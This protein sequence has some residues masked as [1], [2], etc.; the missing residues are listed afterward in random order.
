MNYKFSDIKNNITFFHVQEKII[1]AIL[2][3]IA[4]DSRNI[5]VP[6][7]ALFFALKGQRLDAHEFIMEAYQKGVRNFIVNKTFD[8]QE[9]SDANF[10]AVDNVVHA[11]QEIATFHRKHF[12]ITTIGIT[13]SNGKTIIKEWLFQ[14]LFQDH[15]I[16]RS[17]RSY[18]SQIGVPLS[19]LAI[20]KQH[21]LAIFEAGI[22]RINEMEKLANVIRCNIG[23]FTNIGDAHD[24]GFMSRVQKIKEKMKLF[25]FCDIL[26]LCN[27]NDQ[28]MK[29]VPKKIKT[30]TWGKTKNA[31]L[32][33]NTQKN[34]MTFTST[35]SVTQKNGQQFNYTIPFIDEA[36]IENSIHCCCLML[37]LGYEIAVI[38]RRMIQL[39]AVALRLELKSGINNCLIIN[40]FYNLDVTSLAFAMDFMTQQ[41]LHTKRTL[42]LSDIQQSG[43]APEQLY[44][45]VAQLI[46][47]HQINKVIAIGSTIVNLLPLISQKTTY[48]HY[49]TTQDFLT[50]IKSQDFYQET[51]LLKGARSFEFERIA[52]L[53]ELKAHQTIMEINLDALRHNLVAYTRKLSPPTKMLVM[54]KAS[55]YGSG[56]A[57]IAKLLEYHKVDYLGVA[58]TDEAVA[59][60][61]EG[62]KLPILVLNPEEASFHALLH[63]DIEPEIYS[64]AQL[65]GLLSYVENTSKI[66]NIHIKLDTGMH[67]L[68]FEMPDIQLL[69]NILASQKKLY[70]KSIFSHLAASDATEHDD[71][72]TQQV[73]QFLAMYEQIATAIGYRPLRHICNTSG[74]ARFPQYHFDMVRLGIGIYG[75][76]SSQEMQSDLQVVNT[77]KATI[78]QIKHIPKGES[79]GYSRRGLAERDLR[80]GTISIGYADGFLRAAGNG[81]YQ[82]AIHGKLAPIIGNVCMDMC[83]IDLTEIQEAKEGDKVTIFGD[84]PRVETLAKATQTIAYEVFTNISERVKR[85]YFKE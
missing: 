49:N 13:G 56:S 53:L 12:A 47:E 82:V 6:S 34:K 54:V 21:D 71:F 85:I 58:Y 19:I 83:M 3:H 38:Q 4:M 68:G 64:L 30:F 55:A 77:L 24:E 48:L 16:V 74:I 40:D 23:I 8:F 10:I 52:E 57:E 43:L 15:F 17:P 67:R 50:N 46:V 62:I 72:T 73:N 2:S 76:D 78:S 69:I 59:L 60:R 31:D 18:N 28:I 27:D 35:I 33:V 22:S 45:K 37:Y 32:K 29:E 14:L 44:T 5:A 75:V 20:E 66:L 84:F 65:R 70:I 63:Y 41:A 80:I 39:Q 11:L 81:R 79:I 9:F 51:I 61:K 7:Q 36:A 25:Q 26:I 1:P 42:I